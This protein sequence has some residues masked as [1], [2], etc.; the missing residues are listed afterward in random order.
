[1]LRKFLPVSLLFEFCLLAIDITGTALLNPVLSKANAAAPPIVKP[2][3]E[4]TVQ[5]TNPIPQRGSGR[6]IKSADP[7]WGS[8][9][10]IQ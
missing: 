3:E 1:M 9:P 10:F 8:T 2:E 7:V 4:Q 5:P 6:N